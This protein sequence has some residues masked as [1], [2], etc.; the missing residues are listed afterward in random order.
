MNKVLKIALF[1]YSTKPR[2]GV[3]HTLELG[4]ALQAEGH[5]VCIYAL[6][7]DNLGFHRFLSCSSKLIPTK[8]VADRQLL[9]SKKTGCFNKDTEVRNFA[10]VDALIKQRIQ[11][12]TDYLSREIKKY[13]I[14]H[15]QDCISANALKFLRD[16]GMISGFIRTVHHIDE[17]NSPYLQKCQDRSILEPDLCLSVSQY[18]RQ[19]L[20]KQYQIDAPVIINGVNSQ[21]FS[22]KVNGEERKLKQQL[23]IKSNPVYLTIGGIEPRKNSLKLLEA[24]SEV[25]KTYPQ[26]QLII[27]GGETLFD[28][29]S[30]RLEFFNLAQRNNLKIGE[31]LILP[32]VIP[33]KDIPV[34]YRCA[35]AFV[36]PSVKEGWG[37]VLLEAIASGLPIITSDILPFTEFLNEESALL[38]NPNSS[39]NIAIAMVDILN[40]NL[41]QK[42]VN[43]SSTIPALYSWQ[44]SAKMHLKHY[45]K[46]LQR[47]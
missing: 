31:S 43:N 4:E 46:L 20:Q 29:E 17:F 35:D 5:N 42:L 9:L 39:N 40:K 21:K 38:V 27:A 12:F 47:F 16:R 32:G 28:Y 18:W 37:L 10:P 44:K 34:L 1:T 15:S 23:G 41:A 26:A 3:I 14:Y 11:E 24:F 2:G 22:S 8:P 6:D 19:Q 25:L 33:D 45:S 13:D 30:Y 36:F 7:K